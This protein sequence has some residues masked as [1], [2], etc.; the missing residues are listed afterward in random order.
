MLY[1]LK[2]AV[3]AEVTA[4]LLI[5]RALY[6]IAPLLVGM[7]TLVAHEIYSGSVERG[8]TDA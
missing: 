8:Q 2:D 1:L 4:S 6:Y 3:G 5:F 7:V